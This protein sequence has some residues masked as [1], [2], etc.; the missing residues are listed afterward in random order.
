MEKTHINPLNFY[1]DWII[2]IHLDVVH[3][4]C[5]MYLKYN[6]PKFIFY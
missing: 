6:T 4:N 3:P 2:N 5:I 1:Q